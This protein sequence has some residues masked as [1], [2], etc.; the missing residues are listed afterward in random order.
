MTPTYI[1]TVFA[2]YTGTKTYTYKTLEEVTTGDY[3]AVQTPNGSLA[4]VKVK[5]PDVPEPK[6]ACK[7]AFQKIDL[8]LLAD[9]EDLETKSGGVE[10]L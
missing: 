3:L 8:S 10:R 5:T 4:I 1:E 6:Y 7:W 9:L 2:P